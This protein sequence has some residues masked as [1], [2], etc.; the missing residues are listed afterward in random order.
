MCVI[1]HLKKGVLLPY[2]MFETATFNNPHGYGVVLKDDNRLEVKRECPEKGNDPEKIYKLLVDNK[3]IER[4]VHLRWKTQG[5]ICLDN[6]QPFPAYIS[7][8]RQ[9]WFMHN[10]SLY[11]YT[12]KITQVNGTTT[13]TTTDDTISDSR[14]FCETDLSDLLLR[15]QGE[16]GLGDIQDPMFIKTVN[17]FWAT[18]SKG[19]LISSDQDPLY[20]SGSAWQAI[21]TGEYDQWTDKKSKP[22]V[23]H[24]TEIKFMASNDDYFKE[25]KRGPVFE[26]RKK[27]EEDRRA[28]ERLANPPVEETRR[29]GPLQIVPLS[30]AAFERRF[31]MVKRL[32]N[33]MVD[34]DIYLPEGAAALSALTIEE[35]DAWV[36]ENPQDVT[37]M[38]VQLTE[39]LKKVVDER[40]DL[41]G[42]LASAS[43]RIESYVKAEKTNAKAA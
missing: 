3:D 1:I 31:A 17:K 34:Y 37:P 40:D 27:D 39:H 13:I 28:A 36:K 12:K 38:L 43:K 25:L 20:L 4:F 9:V 32:T 8:K 41:T 26:A 23:T 6:T 24:S 22:P 30:S 7:D 35:F 16:Q 42:K 15:M 5:D 10:G 19:I 11:D 18:A 33:L 21:S 29:A 2:K 14:N